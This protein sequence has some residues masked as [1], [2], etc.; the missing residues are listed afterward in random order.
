MACRIVL[1]GRDGSPE[2]ATRDLVVPDLGQ[3]ERDDEY[4]RAVQ[5]RLVSDS[6]LF[7]V[8]ERASILAWPQLLPDYP[9]FVRP[10]ELLAN[11]EGVH[12]SFSE[13]HHIGIAVLT[14]LGGCNVVIAPPEVSRNV[15]RKAAAERDN[16][17]TAADHWFR[18]QPAGE[19]VSEH[20]AVA[21]H[22]LDVG[23][24]VAE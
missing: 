14:V 13:A 8:A 10:F 24:E 1:V 2:N 21:A 9:V 18:R 3:P 5:A 4:V 12:H 15:F 6:D 23:I 11:H 7:W 20:R 17:R 16:I 19:H 22:I